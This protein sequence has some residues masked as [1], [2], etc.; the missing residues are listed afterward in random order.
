MNQLSTTVYVP[1]VQ[2]AADRKYCHSCG[3]VLHHS[4]TNCTACGA[5][6]SGVPAA[7]Y[8]QPSQVAGGTA[9]ALPQHHVFCRGCGAGIHESAVTCPKCGAP[10]RVGTGIGHAKSRT[11]AVLLAFLLGGLGAHRFYLGNIFVGL[12]YLFF[13]WTFIPSILALIEGVYFLTHSD[14]EFSRKHP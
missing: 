8:M 5:M 10:Q 13:C 9:S 6:Q 4:A 12:L 14:E 3:T 1:A 2:K 11:T 7:P